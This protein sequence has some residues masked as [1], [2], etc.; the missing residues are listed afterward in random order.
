M[1]VFTSY[2]RYNAVNVNKLHKVLCWHVPLLTC[3]AAVNSDTLSRQ[4]LSIGR[5]SVY[6]FRIRDAHRLYVH[7][8]Y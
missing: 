3:I 5:E 1:H 4:V 6:M 8:S 2:G 7:V